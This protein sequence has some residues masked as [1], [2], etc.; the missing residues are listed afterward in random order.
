MKTA[1]TTEPK[2]KISK[3]RL[4]CMLR[5]RKII[6]ACLEGKPLKETA[7]AV[8]LSPRSA[9]TQ[10]SQ[11][12]KEPKV[13][14]YFAEILETEGLSDKILAEKLQY[15][16]NARNIIYFQHKGRVTDERDVP[17]HET[18]RKTLELIARLKGH[19]K[20]ADRGSVDV[21]VNLMGLVVQALKQDQD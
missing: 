9:G 8:G 4:D 2:R 12:L 19:L 3:T 6:E 1:T 11:I 18:Q 14:Q 17:A 5:R 15:L 20:E 13:Q 7:I 21:Q 10:V 16:L